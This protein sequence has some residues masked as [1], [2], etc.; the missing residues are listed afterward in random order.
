MLYACTQFLVS[1][2]SYQLLSFIFSFLPTPTSWPRKES[3]TLLW[4][5]YL[6]TTDLELRTGRDYY[7]CQVLSLCWDESM[8]DW[9]QEADSLSVL[10]RAMSPCI[11]DTGN[12]GQIPFWSSRNSF[13][14]QLWN[15]D[16]QQPKLENWKLVAFPFFFCFLMRKIQLTM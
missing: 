11:A 3:V 16:T 8:K 5:L 15:Q 4:H 13:W 1:N 7:E 10:M 9:P 2:P 12:I 6:S 14:I